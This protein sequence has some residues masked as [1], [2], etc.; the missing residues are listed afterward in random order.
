MPPDDLVGLVA[1]AARG[2]E[3]SV[4]AL[5]ERLRQAGREAEARRLLAL[6]TVGPAVA[7]KLHALQDHD[8][9]PDDYGRGF[10]AGLLWVKGYLDRW[11]GTADEGGS[12]VRSE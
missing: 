8:P 5:L 1:D 9:G 11:G 3:A 10:A 12:D 4:A 7:V 6:L 2:D